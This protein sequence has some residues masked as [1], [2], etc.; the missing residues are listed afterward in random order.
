MGRSIHIQVD[1]PDDIFAD[2]DLH[3]QF[4][5]GI[6]N[7]LSRQFC[8]LIDGWSW[9]QGGSQMDDIG[10]IARVDVKPIWEM[11]HYRQ[12]NWEELDI[13]LE[14]AET[15]EEKNQILGREKQNLE[16]LTNNLD[17]VLI[18][19]QELIDKFPLIANQIEATGK[20]SKQYFSMPP[21]GQEDN[22]EDYFFDDIVKFKDFLTFVKTK[23]TT[24]VF[25]EFS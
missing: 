12:L 24:T 21:A 17:R 15:E 5:F 4:E 22:S 18:T 10:Q 3:F 23:G 14:L 19:I 2:H 8:N 7:G 6:K 11:E 1:S 25:F 9:E 16:K 20:C 13:M